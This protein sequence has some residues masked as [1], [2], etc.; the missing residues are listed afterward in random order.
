MIIILCFNCMMIFNFPTE[1]IFIIL[2]YYIIME[3]I[4]AIAP[5]RKKRLFRI[6]YNLRNSHIITIL[7]YYI[8]LSS[9]IIGIKSANIMNENKLYI[10]L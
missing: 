1:L 3:N 5:S 6:I 9:L 8:K 10:Q 4:I 2:L 7:Y